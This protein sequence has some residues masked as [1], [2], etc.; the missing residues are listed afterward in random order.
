MARHH[1]I[2]Y[3]SFYTAGSEA[4]KVDWQPVKKQVNLPQPRRAK[5][6]VVYVDP[7]ANIGIVVAVVMLLVML[8]GVV[9]FAGVHN[10]RVQLENY[11][12]TLQQKNES[13]SDTYYA[14]FDPE[15]IRQ[16][17]LAKG[18]IPAEQAQVMY[19][20]VPETAEQPEETGSLW[21]FLLRLFA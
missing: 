19:V 2:Q 15:E 9:R 12:S 8:V 10:Q 11:V 17:A 21:A 6:K 5:R 16:I 20:S 4:R 13:L 3:V 7:V 18:L 1:Q 14:G